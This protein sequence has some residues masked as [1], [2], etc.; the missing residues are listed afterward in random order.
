MESK[1][2]TCPQKAER[3]PS[4]SQKAERYAVAITS[5]QFAPRAQTKN[6]GLPG[7]RHGPEA[8]YILQVSSPVGTTWSVPKTYDNFDVLRQQLQDGG[9]KINHFPDSRLFGRGNKTKYVQE[10]VVK[11][12]AFL[13]DV[14][15]NHIQNTHI[16]EF[17]QIERQ[18]RDYDELCG[19]MIS[20]PLVADG[21]GST[22]AEEIFDHYFDRY[23]LDA[24]GRINSADALGMLTLNLLTKFGGEMDASLPQ[25]HPRPNALHE[26]DLIINAAK[27]D[28]EETVACNPD[29]FVTKDAYCGWFDEVF[30]LGHD[31]SFIEHISASSSGVEPEGADGEGAGPVRA[32]AE[33]AG[34]EYGDCCLA[35]VSYALECRP[36]IA[37]GWQVDVRQA[38]EAGDIPLL[39]AIAL[40][41]PEKVQQAVNSASREGLIAIVNVLLAERI[42]SRAE[43]P[44]DRQNTL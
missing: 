9:I 33:G 12:Q 35:E 24:S 16:A 20:N 34:A 3:H 23:D 4:A 7:T 21:S 39:E 17:L 15:L 19:Q 26:I 32:G 43:S 8:Y 41:S 44:R 13:R 2:D 28:M 10:R 36:L 29:F 27:A 1:P 30:F 42:A 14:V 5:T 31:V 6:R 40:S 37:C 38:V 11:F 18:E 25:L 22:P